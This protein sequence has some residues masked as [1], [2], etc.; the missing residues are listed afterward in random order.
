MRSFL[1]YSWSVRPGSVIYSTLIGHFFPSLWEILYRNPLSKTIRYE[2]KQDAR[3][4]FLLFPTNN[5]ICMCSSIFSLWES[6]IHLSRL[7][8]IRGILFHYLKKKA[9]V[10]ARSDPHCEVNISGELA[11][12]SITL[13][14]VSP[15]KLL[16]KSLNSLPSEAYFKG[17]SCQGIHKCQNCSCFCKLAVDAV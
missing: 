16:R 10:A 12:N 11:A 6:G 14:N 3:F 5:D 7:F 4:P 17:R 2:W 13:F 1:F 9:R 8:I 15:Q